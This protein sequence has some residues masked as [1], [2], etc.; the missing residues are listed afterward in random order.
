MSKLNQLIKELCPNGVKKY[1]FSE[2]ANF[3]QGIQVDLK[4]QFPEPFDGS[5]QF[6][7]IVDF[8]T[9]TEPPRYIKKPDDRYIKK[10]GEL[11]MIRYGASAAGKVFT[12]KSGAIANNMFKINLI[13]DDINP[14]YIKYYLSQKKIYNLLNNASGK[15]TMPAVNFK[16]LSKIQISIPPIEIQDE[17]V[18]ILDKF[19]ELEAELEARRK[20]KDIYTEQLFS[21]D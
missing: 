20:Q 17:I 3:S 11:I 8:V 15:S 14:E 19:N 7:R 1:Y 4:E 16:F 9:S 13:K 6:L 5:I 18:K 10:S 2:I 12:E 21:F